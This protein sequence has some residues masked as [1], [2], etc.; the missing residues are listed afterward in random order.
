MDN[1]K[2]DFY[3]ITKIKHDLSFIVEH[4]KMIE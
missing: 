1:T 4:M 2:N 3:Y